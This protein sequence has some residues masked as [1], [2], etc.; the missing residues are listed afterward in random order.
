MVNIRNILFIVFQAV[1]ISGL[2]I[3]SYGQDY[4]SI[5][6]KIIDEKTTQPLPFAHISLIEHNIGTI[7]NDEGEF[8]L[9]IP[10]SYVDDSLVVSYLGYKNYKCSAKNLTAGIILISLKP[11][12]IPIKEVAITTEVLNPKKIIKKAIKRI[13]ENYPND[14]EIFTGFYRE[15]VKEKDTYY[16]LIE[17][18]L[19]FKKF[20]YKHEDPKP[21]LHRKTD[22]YPL[23]FDNQIKSENIP[24]LPEDVRLMK[25]RRNQSIFYSRIFNHFKIEGGPY[26]CVKR[27]IVK[28]KIDFIE[29]T[30]FRFYDYRYSGI[31]EFNGRKVY[32]IIFDQK[33]KV[34]KP[35][36]KGIIYIDVQTLAFVHFNYGLSSKGLSYAT[37]DLYV[38]KNPEHIIVDPISSY[39]SVDYAYHN[40]GMWRFHYSKGEIQLKMIKNDWNLSSVLTFQDVLLATEKSSIT[41]DEFNGLV[42]FKP[43][44]L[45]NDKIYDYHED[46]WGEY[47]IIR[48]NKELTNFI[49]NLETKEI[50]IPKLETKLYHFTEKTRSEKLYVQLD[51]YLYQPGDTLWFKAYTFFCPT[52]ISSNL[53]NTLYTVL[54]DQDGNQ[55]LDKKFLLSKEGAYGDFFLPDTLEDGFYKFIAYTSWMKNFEPEN[56]FTCDIEIRQIFNKDFFTR[57]YF[58]K[59]SYSPG[60]IVKFIVHTMTIQKEPVT[61]VRYSYE[62]ISGK[63]KIVEGKSKTSENGKD[64]IQFTLPESR[65]SYL[66]KLIITHNKE[67]IEKVYNIPS[68][69]VDIDLQFFPEGGDMVEGLESRIAFKAIDE[70]GHPFDFKGELLNENKNV[71]KNIQTDHKG[72]GSFI[73]TPLI[74]QSYYVRLTEPVRINKLFKLPEPESNG[75]VLKIDTVTENNIRLKIKSSRPDKQEHICIFVQIRGI[76]Y[77]AAE[78]KITDE[79]TMSIPTINMPAGIAQ[80]TLFNAAQIP[81]AERLVFVN[82]HRKLYIR[83]ETDKETYGPRE[84]VIATIKTKDESGN[85]VPA[86]FS[87]AVTDQELTVSPEIKNPNIL[88]SILLQSELKGDIPTPNFYFDETNPLAG[89]ALDLVMMTHGW[90][91]FSW[92]TFLKTD[93]NALPEPIAFD[94]VSGKIYRT[95]G[96]PAGYA[97]ISI[98]QLYP[99]EIFEIQ[100]DD[101]GSFKFD[102]QFTPENFN[103]IVLVAKSAKGRKNVTIELAEQSNDQFNSELEKYFN[104]FRIMPS[105]YNFSDFYI[106]KTDLL[107]EPMNFGDTK[108]IPEVIIKAK[109]KTP[110]ESIEAYHAKT[111]G[112]YKKGEELNSKLPFEHWIIQINPRAKLTSDGV[113]FEGGRY[114]LKGSPFTQTK[115]PPLLVLDGKYWGISFSDLRILEQDQIESIG[116]LSSSQAFMFFGERAKY[117]AIIVTT[118]KDYVRKVTLNENVAFL[119]FYAPTR[120]FY[121][122]KY[123]SE[124]ERNSKIPD[125]RTT[126]YWE[127]NLVID[128]TGE[129]TVTFYNADRSCK[130]K[131]LVEGVG[132]GGILGYTEFN[133]TVKPDTVIVYLE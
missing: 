132:S 120:E 25:G 68:E 104:S 28:N 118:K 79:A 128:D 31:Q 60:D 37:G 106:K 88:S 20:P 72:I 27:D 9:K 34:K 131:G 56:V 86:Q 81:M 133:Y 74:N 109:K 24:E 89:Q 7:S 41:E 102:F 57:L 15:S 75:Y 94:M 46:F 39:F 35:L 73:L 108:L 122:P 4:V 23:L 62:L 121:S 59:T 54:L 100:A 45:L 44:E 40:D 1:F 67:E 22:Y 112:R 26:Y 52:N 105:H 90:R 101:Q 85:M 70:F 71:I 76:K 103:K 61:R 111:F 30:S 87:L 29:K 119:R 84:R 17:A 129:A 91:R 63:E 113:V 55:I 92:D 110:E 80:I 117:G 47:N 77:W 107:L 11:D 16:D 49:N 127:P 5:Y 38:R 36:Y 53:S 18:V 58:D 115:G 10:E 19:F 64:T 69:V 126:I 130:I 93:I 65:K 42:T 98:T 114:N 82:K 78:G 48:P 50:I 96:K 14:E 51:K 97:N 83:V 3:S 8:V 6:G 32:K 95:D 123:E 66:L 21:D 2:C 33:D 43:D 99:P 12:E 13:P 125:L 124:Q 116:T